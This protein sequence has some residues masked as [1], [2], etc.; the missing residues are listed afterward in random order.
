MQPSQ[1]SGAQVLP[2][3]ASPILQLGRVTQSKELGT[4]VQQFQVSLSVP[5][6]EADASWSQFSLEFL[7]TLWILAFFSLFCAVFLFV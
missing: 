5:W 1:P 7:R 6:G 3:L 2:E 4:Q